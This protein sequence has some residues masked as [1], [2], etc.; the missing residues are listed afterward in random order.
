MIAL[1]S[2]STLPSRYPVSGRELG[3]LQGSENPT[4]P[5]RVLEP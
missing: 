3:V 5:N 2:C 1:E 4:S